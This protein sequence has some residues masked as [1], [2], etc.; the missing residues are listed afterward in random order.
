MTILWR[1]ATKRDRVLLQQFQCTDP[2]GPDFERLVQRYFRVQAIAHMGSHDSLR[3]D[4]RLLLVLDED[5]LVA[6]GCHRRGPQAGQ[7]NFVFAAVASAFQGQE[8]SNGV[9][10][11]DALWSVVA[12]DILDRE[13]ADPVD[14]FARVDRGNARSLAFCTRI[15]LA[16][17]GADR[18]GLVLCA[19]TI[20]RN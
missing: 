9:R 15:G 13:Q 8:L 6:A 17:R 5:E 2:D 18:N 1:P 7:R 16:T 20:A 4:H 3:T 11:S 10:A 19:G 14:V 12:N